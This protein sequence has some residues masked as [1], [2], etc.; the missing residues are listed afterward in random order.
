PVEGVVPI[1]LHHPYY[2]KR[3]LYC[4][5]NAE[6]LFTENETNNRRLFGADNASS[7]VKDGINDYIVHGAKEAVNAAGWGTKAAGNYRIKIEPGQSSVVK[8]RLTDKEMASAG[9]R[10]FSASFDTTFADRRKETD[11]F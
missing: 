2:G 7:H 1:E 10:P 9:T 3:W 4:E 6:P 11:E 5:G 8:L